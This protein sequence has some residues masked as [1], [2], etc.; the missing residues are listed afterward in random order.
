[1]NYLMIL[2][3]E[4]YRKSGQIYTESAFCEHLRLFRDSLSPEVSKISILAPEMSPTEF[5]HRGNYLGALDEVDESIE[6]TPL[7]PAGT[8]RVSYLLKYLL[9]NALRIYKAVKAADV[10]HAGPSHLYYP[11][12]I[13]GILTG[14]VL[15][16]KTVFLVDIDWRSAPRMNFVRSP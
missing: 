8:G 6:W 13:I 16:K 7:E 14:I 5:E 10:V 12:E 3:V 2:P 11:R 9:R 4:F 15:R 1:M